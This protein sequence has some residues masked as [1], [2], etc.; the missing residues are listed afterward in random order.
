MVKVVVV[1]VEAGGLF[2]RLRGVTGRNARAYIT[3]A[4]TGTARGTELRKPFPVGK[5]VEA[6]VLEIDPKAGEAKLSIKAL[7]E[8][9]ERCAYN[10][11]RDLRA[12]AR[13]CPPS[14]RLRLVGPP[15]IAPRQ[16]EPLREGR[17]PEP[18]FPSALHLGPDFA[19]LES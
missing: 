3:A 11:R 2:M 6:K 10:G 12:R 18:V 8:E 16:S 17:S 7:A 13:G 4:A 15:Q 14:P 9:S 5:E 19:I 1:G